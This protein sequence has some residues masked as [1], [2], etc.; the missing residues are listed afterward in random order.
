MKKTLIFIFAAIILLSFPA[1]AKTADFENVFSLSDTY[2]SITFDDNSELSAFSGSFEL[3][4]GVFGADSGVLSVSDAK[5]LLPKDILYA[6]NSVKFDIFIP[7]ETSSAEIN[8]NM[9]NKNAVLSLAQ[10]DGEISAAL[11]RQKI[12]QILSGKWYTVGISADLN[13]KNLYIGIDGV[14]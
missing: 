1:F 10:K 9:Q 5:F 13:E 8:V 14:C 11:G 7:D 12:A 2:H 4:N 3:Q 6:K